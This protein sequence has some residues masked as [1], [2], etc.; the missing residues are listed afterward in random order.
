MYFMEL[1]FGQFASKGPFSIWSCSPIA[2]GVGAAMVLVCLVIS[3]YY[4]VVMSYTLYYIGYSF[5]S[6]LPWTSCDGDWTVGTNCTVR[7]KYV[8]ELELP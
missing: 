6:V 8:S 2:R 3:V 7:T 4:N 1:S 5:T